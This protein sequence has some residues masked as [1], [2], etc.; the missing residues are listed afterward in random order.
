MGAIDLRGISLRS[1]STGRRHWK[2]LFA[3][4]D[5]EL[6]DVASDPGEMR[7]LSIDRKRNGELLLAMNDRLNDLIAS[8]VGDDSPDAMP[9]RNG[10]VLVQVRKRH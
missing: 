10:K 3:R 9:I 7:N 8:E 1:I 5:V 6:Y 4:N 2:N